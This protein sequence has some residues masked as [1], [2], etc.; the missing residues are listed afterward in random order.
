MAKQYIG[1]W[2]SGLALAT[3]A[4]ALV[5]ITNFL[6]LFLS[7][8]IIS[9]SSNGEGYLYSGN[10][11]TA[12]E[13]NIWIHLVINVLSTLLLGASNYTKQV[14]TGPTRDEIVIAHAQEM[15]LQIGVPSLRNL[16]M[17]SRRRVKAW[18]LLALSAL[19]IHLMYDPLMS[20]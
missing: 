4:V 13:Y 17:I 11:K 18:I 7:V 2:R 10:C 8:S 20:N 6:F 5:T 3:L 12:K 19:P 14:L 9:F 1:G 16:A 15:A